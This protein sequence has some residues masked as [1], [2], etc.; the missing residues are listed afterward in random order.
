M[1]Q[2]D[3]KK[4]EGAWLKV[5]CPDARCLREEEIVEIPGD[6]RTK[7]EAGSDKGLWLE[8][9]CPDEACLR[10]E[11]QIELPVRRGMDRERGGVWLNLFCPDDK[12]AIEDSTDLA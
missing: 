8:V 4:T 1:T 9:F 5:F 6:V 7:A 12:C 10:D 3:S 2:T 11:D